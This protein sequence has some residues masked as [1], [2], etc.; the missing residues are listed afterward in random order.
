MNKL[1]TKLCLY[2]TVQIDFISHAIKYPNGSNQVFPDKSEPQKRDINLV[3]RPP[4]F[5]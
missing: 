1:C 4:P 3:R 2:A 5:R